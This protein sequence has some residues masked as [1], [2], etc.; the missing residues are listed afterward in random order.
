MVLDRFVIDVRSLLLLRSFVRP[1]VRSLCSFA[2]S[3]VRSFI[4]SLNEEIRYT[5][6]A[7]CYLFFV[8]SRSFIRVSVRSFVRS[9]VRPFV[10]ASTR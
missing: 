10:R 6:K 1:F 7:S 8:R 3:C 2:R 5:Q 9:F 4:H